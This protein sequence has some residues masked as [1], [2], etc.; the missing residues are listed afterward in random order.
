[1][2]RLAAT[3]ALLCSTSLIALAHRSLGDGGMQPTFSSRIEGVRIDVLVTDS[4][5][6]PLRDLT[7][8]D[9]VIRDNGVLQTVDAVSFGELSLNVGLTFDLSDSVAGARHDQLR[10]ASRELTR[11]LLPPDQVSL[12]TFNQVVTLRCPPSTMHGCIDTALADVTP[13]HETALVDGVFAAMTIGE[14]DAGRSLQMVFSDGLDTASFLEPARILDMGRRSDVVVYPIVTK[15][16]KPE[17]LEELA[18]LTGGR[19][20]E[21]DRKDEL[22]STF[23]EILDEFRYRSLLTY[24]PANVAKGGYHKLDVRV[25]RPG[26]RIRARPGYQG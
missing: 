17:F 3:L 12:I 23:K 8:R 15:G 19:L 1:V 6:R 14:W 25:N 16:A 18:S 4:S 20:Y 22:S 9:F 7:A 26:A 13:A 5:R 11:S 21:I 24:T 2:I 10:Q